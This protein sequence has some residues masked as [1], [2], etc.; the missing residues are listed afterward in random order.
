VVMMVVG[1]L[2]SNWVPQTVPSITVV[3]KDNRTGA[4]RGNGREKT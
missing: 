2:S 3:R 1:P 4:A